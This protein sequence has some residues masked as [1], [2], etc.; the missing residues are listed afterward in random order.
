MK[1]STSSVHAAEPMDEETG[2]VTTP[3]YQSTTCGFTRAEEVAKAVKGESSSFVYTRWDN[4][5]VRRLE[6]KLAEL[7]GAEDSAFF[8]AGMAAI[9]TSVLTFVREGSHVLA[10]RDLYGE[11]YKLIHE[12]LPGLGVE[13]TMVETTDLAQMRQNLKKNTKVVYIESTTNPTLKLVDIAKS[14]KLAHSVG[15]VLLIDRPFAPP[16]KQKP[17]SLRADG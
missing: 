15:A 3:I 11:S 14:A 6:R 5:T 17:L 13:T 7:E 9:S 1:D 12:F 4:P 2:S 8:S 16:I 10:V